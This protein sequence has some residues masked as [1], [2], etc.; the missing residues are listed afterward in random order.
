M[1]KLLLSNNNNFLLQLVSDKYKALLLEL[2]QIFKAERNFHT[3]RQILRRTHPPCVPHLGISLTDL[4]YIEQASP[5]LFLGMLNFQKRRAI[6][7]RISWILQ[8]Q[9]D[10]Y[11]FITVPCIQVE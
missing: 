8:F 11:R 3:L 9:Q 5:D 6:A 2:K 1:M 7:D 4:T 10:Y